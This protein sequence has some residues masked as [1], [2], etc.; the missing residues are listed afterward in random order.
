MKIFVSDDKKMLIF[1][2][3]MNRKELI[4][5]LKMKNIE[6]FQIALKKIILDYGIN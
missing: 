2:N 3:I 6:L 4:G 1:D 5:P